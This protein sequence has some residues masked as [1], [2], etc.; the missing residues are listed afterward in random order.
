VLGEVVPQQWQDNR[1]S[2]ERRHEIRQ[3][4][5]SGEIDAAVDRVL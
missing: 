1:E 3:L 2:I 4:V 5:V